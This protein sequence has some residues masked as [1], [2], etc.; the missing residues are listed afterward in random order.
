MALIEVQHL[1]N[2][3]TFRM[4]LSTQWMMSVL[5]LKRYD[6]GGCW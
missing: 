5:R 6:D 1:K 3:L 2:I 4:E